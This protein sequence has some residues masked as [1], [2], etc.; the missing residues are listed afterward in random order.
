MAISEDNKPISYQLPDLVPSFNER[1]S[2]A[3]ALQLDIMLVEAVKVN[4][5]IE[6]KDPNQTAQNLICL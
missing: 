2:F 4:A 5:S 6:A 1:M 3:T